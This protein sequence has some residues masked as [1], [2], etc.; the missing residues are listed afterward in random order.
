MRAHSKFLEYY[1]TGGR[2]NREL[3]MGGRRRKGNGENTNE[4]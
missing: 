3:E 1:C 4:F 2:G